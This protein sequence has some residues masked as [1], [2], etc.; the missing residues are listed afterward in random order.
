MHISKFTFRWA[1][2]LSLATV[3]AAWAVARA[4]D[5]DAT[6]AS[7]KAAKTDHTYSPSK[8]DVPSRTATG[9]YP[10]SPYLDAE[11]ADPDVH[12]VLYSDENVMLLEVS[13][14][15]GLDV[16]M[17]GH[18]YAT[19]SGQDTAPGSGNPNPVPRAT[20]AG[21]GNN[22]NDPKIEPESPYNDMGSGRGE[23]AKGVSFLTCSTSAP[24]APHK[25]INRGA[26][27]L[28]FYRMEFRRLDGDDIQSHWKEW[29]PDMTKPETPVK[30]LV[31]GPALG[32]NFS[33]KWPYPIVY[34]S[35][36]AAPNN[37]HLLFED[38][39]L[40]FI[41]VTIRPG[42][43]TPMFGDP[44]PAVLA[45]NTTNN[46]NDPSNVKDTNLDPNSELNGQGSGF[47]RAPNVRGMKVP[48][49][50]TTAPRAPHKVYNAGTAPLHYYRIEYKRIDGEDFKTN[51]QKWY[52]WMLYMKY[53]R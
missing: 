1:V 6:D 14:P 39:K 51:W 31:S 25:P 27:P 23:P 48:T 8:L 34:D 7:H 19:V 9:G 29:Y 52:P 30:D 20:P 2:V 42:E 45:F 32:P 13:N 43:T 44:Y 40:R 10:F 46:L 50:M 17:H 41:E 35:I 33:D 47:G 4:Q 37:F 22:L 36:K 21:N 28:H 3:G 18:P 26:V 24:Q 12:R 5:T 16:H 11:I 15:P 38:G 49:C 53:M